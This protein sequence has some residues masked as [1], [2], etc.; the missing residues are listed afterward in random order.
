MSNTEQLVRV[1]QRGPV[2]W[3]VIDSPAN[4]NALGG[5]VLAGLVFGLK[6]ALASPDVRVI[7]LT[8]TGNV[9]SSG[10]DLR[11]TTDLAV[12]EQAYRD[13]FGGILDADKPVVARINGHCFGGAIGLAAVCDL[14]VTDD[15]AIFSFSEVRLGRTATLASVVSLPRLRPGDAAE[16]LL[17]GTRID[18]SRAAALGLVNK[19]VPGDQLDAEI[20]DIVTDLLAGGPMALANT[21]QLIRQVPLITQDEAWDLAFQITRETAGSAEA[22]EGTAAFRE[23]RAP[24]WPALAP[25]DRAR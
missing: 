1:E 17:R 14:S 22:I 16:L 19:S 15:K 5:P 10:A 7:V 2:A 12:I 11:D 21:K 23:K 3:L 20:D 24:I 6:G 18:G 25:R 9:F 13:L 8:A 4:R